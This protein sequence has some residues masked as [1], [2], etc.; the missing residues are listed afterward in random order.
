M[1]LCKSDKGIL[2]RYVIFKLKRY[3]KIQKKFR[4]F[5]CKQCSKDATEIK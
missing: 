5:A 3:L 4:L 2:T 1:Y